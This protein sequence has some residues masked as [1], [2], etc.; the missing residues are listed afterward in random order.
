LAICIVCGK[1]D[2]V[3]LKKA[4]SQGWVFAKCPECQRGIPLDILAVYLSK[5]MEEKY[6]EGYCPKHWFKDSGICGYCKMRREGV[7][8]IVP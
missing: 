2:E 7:S 5:T 1:F 6:L 4:M 3:D 8:E